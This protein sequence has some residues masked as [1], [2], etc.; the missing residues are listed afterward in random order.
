MAGIYKLEDVK[1]YIKDNIIT[2]TSYTNETVE[3]IEE[4][5]NLISNP[6]NRVNDDDKQ[7][8]AYTTQASED[9]TVVDA[10]EEILKQNNYDRTREVIIETVN[11][12]GEMFESL[13]IELKPRIPFYVFVLDSLI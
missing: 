4:C 5:Y 3:R 2:G 10:I 6:F 13:G 9:V 11:E 12:V 7:W 1:K 8:V